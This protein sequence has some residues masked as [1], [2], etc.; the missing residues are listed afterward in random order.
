[1][2]GSAASELFLLGQALILMLRKE[3]R[4]MRDGQ[5]VPILRHLHLTQLSWVPQNVAD[6]VITPAPA[7]PGAG[8]PAAGGP[9]AGGF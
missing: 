4:V 2:I 7:G 1:M 9:G 3:D 6:C 5:W 8:D